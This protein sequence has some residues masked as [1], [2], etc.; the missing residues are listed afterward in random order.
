MARRSFPTLDRM[1]AADNSRL[2]CPFCAGQVSRVAEP[3]EPASWKESIPLV[4]VT[5]IFLSCGAI[6]V[7]ALSFW[8]LLAAGVLFVV[9]GIVWVERDR[10]NAAYRCEGCG[11][12]LTYKEARRGTSRAV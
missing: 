3:V 4:L 9:A 8:S 12:V 10:R 7:I 1:D 6:L 2:A 5:D 11:T